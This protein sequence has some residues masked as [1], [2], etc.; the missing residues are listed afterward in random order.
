MLNDSLKRSQFLRRLRLRSLRLALTAWAGLAGLLMLSGA[1]AFASG[2]PSIEALSASHVTQN[3]ATLEAQINPEGLETT[4]ELRIGDP[5]PRSE[6]VRNV[7]LAKGVIPAQAPE[8]A[9]SV[10]LA[11]SPEHLEIQPGTQYAY[12]ILA[13][14]ASGTVEQHAV[15]ETLVTPP[16]IDSESVSN[17]SEHDATLDAEIN[18]NG[19]YTGYEFQ[20]DPNGSYDL[21]GPDCPFELPGYA[22]CEGFHAGEP[23]PA[24]LAEP[25]PAYIPADT[26]EQSVSLDLASIGATLQPATTYH[27]HVLAASGG[28]P[29]VQGGDETF[30]TPSPSAAG[31]GQSETINPPPVGSGAP[32]SAP[33]APLPG[34]RIDA[35]AAAQPLTRAQK[36]A[37]ALKA[38]DRKPKRER[39][40]CR[41]EAVRKYA[42]A[43]RANSKRA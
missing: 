7:L 22:Q 4:Y 34:A 15:F 41:Q 16:T 37:R 5:S 43:T 12:V 27:Y 31:G 24:G 28:A 19:R 35:P 3:D 21:P 40:R 2:A 32:L 36:L 29:V 18:P 33:A 9:I 25:Q 1:T 13:T 11:S 38:C 10:D 26:G 6:L 8:E 14:S 42:P 39:S 23:L 30:N 17:V 20:V